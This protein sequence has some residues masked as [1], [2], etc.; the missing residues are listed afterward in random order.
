[1]GQHS[2]FG[3]VVFARPSLDRLWEWLSG[4]SV[5]GTELLY[6]TRKRFLTFTALLTIV[7]SAAWVLLSSGTIAA[8]RPFVSLAPLAF[9]PFPF[10]VLRTRID[11][12]ILA[13]AFLVT[14]YVVVTL[15]AGSLGGVVSTTS[16]F[17]MLIPLLG[18]LLFGIR[19][20]LI[21]VGLVSFTYVGFHVGREFLPPSTY[22][23]RGVSPNEWMRAD[24]VSFWKTSA[25]SFLALAC[26]IAV[27]N[28][29]AVVGRSSALL[30]EAAHQTRDALEARIVAEEVSRSK[31][32]FIA[33]VSQEL[34]TPLDAIIGYSELLIESAKDR[35]DEAGAIDNQH[36]LDAAIG[37]RSQ[38]NNVLRLSAIDAGR[39]H[40]EVE[41]YDL[42]ALVN[43]AVLA[44]SPAAEA[45]G[46]RIIVEHCEEPGLWVIDGRKLDLCLRTLLSNAA[47]F[48]KRG[49]ITVRLAKRDVVGGSWLRLQV[50]DT[51][52][53]IDPMRL[54]QL[55]EPLAQARDGANGSL[56]GMGL[57][58]AVARR[59]ARLLGGDLN[60]ASSK[61]RGA[62]FT[63]D[64]P[65]EFSP[66]SLVGP[67]A[68]RNPD[69]TVPH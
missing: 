40:A 10:L 44:T 45:N 20:G 11:L 52:V 63:L 66:A 38:I 3:N 59:I 6:S 14:V 29:R 31:S 54:E 37:L 12:D 9:T 8:G 42:H 19:V 48:T 21:W 18:T 47:R 28:F 46:N 58:L 24:E 62:C 30:V 39:L 22:V 34:G 69:V 33:N 2:A 57:S 32:E 60:A 56:K 43:D 27:A 17:L 36:V 53:G 15:V 51:G 61:G 13:H 25:M 1:M 55:F 64:L 67:V 68:P 4:D 5:N 50:E 16:Y 7:F 23:V 26:C 49:L 65:A 35:G 41:E